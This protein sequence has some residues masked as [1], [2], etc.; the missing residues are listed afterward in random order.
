MVRPLPIHLGDGVNADLPALRKA[1]ALSGAT[2]L[3]KPCVAVP[4]SPEPILVIGAPPKYPCDFVYAKNWDDPEL[5]K[6]IATILGDPKTRVWTVKDYLARFLGCDVESI[7]ELSDEEVV[8]LDERIDAAKEDTEFLLDE[9]KI[10]AQQRVRR[11]GGYKWGTPH[12]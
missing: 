12:S 9:A 2:T 6:A 7:R 4:G 10:V 3:V 5:P 11:D 8:E 1:K